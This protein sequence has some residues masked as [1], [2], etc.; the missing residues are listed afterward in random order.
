MIAEKTQAAGHQK[1]RTRNQRRTGVTR[2]KLLDAARAVFAEKGLDLTTIDDIT[3]R[4]DVGKGTFY[5]HF[6]TKEGL[7]RSLLKEVMDELATTIQ[8]RCA[9]S[10]DL[11]TLLD[12]LI[13]AHIE[14]F[15]S[16]WEDYVLY[17][18][19]RADLTLVEGYS[20]IETPF[21]EYLQIVE[22]LL[23]GMIKR[24][25][26]APMLRRITIAV[27]GFVSGYY[28]FALIAT[29]EE[30]VDQLMRSLRGAL[31]AGLARFVNEAMPSEG[32]D[33]Q[34]RVAW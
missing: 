3:T 17:F 34:T 21:L 27:A 6:R 18:Q 1:V 7:I 31:V 22:D 16:R 29:E 8:R 26:S 24:R 14:F 11:K 4:A 13:G 28:S 12:T 33:E 30:D 15:S 23:D 25:L 32:S 20:G 9:D 2:K 19:G 10:T 5:Y